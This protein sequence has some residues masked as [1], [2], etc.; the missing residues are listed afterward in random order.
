MR[1]THTTL[2]YL[3]LSAG[4]SAQ[5]KVIG[6][7]IE[8]FKGTADE[9]RK[10]NPVLAVGTGTGLS[11]VMKSL[12]G[13]RYSGKAPAAIE[14]PKEQQEDLERRQKARERAEQLAKA[15]P[16]RAPST[17]RPVESTLP[18]ITP[19]LRHFILHPEPKRLFELVSLDA[20]NTVKPGQSREDVVAA[21]GKPSN[22][23]SVNGLDDGPREVLTYHVTAERTVAIRLHDGRVTAVNRY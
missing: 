21:L 2:A 3:L 15:G 19:I 11:N 9:V 17:P 18:A 5:D 14:L 8:H 6:D 12:S 22:A 16:R 1:A 20:V 4:L 23:A 13:R 10:A 7:A